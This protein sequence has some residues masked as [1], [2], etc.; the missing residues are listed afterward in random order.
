MMGM[1]QHDDG[2]NWKSSARGDQAWKEVTD[3]VAS[4]NADAR[5][6]G[7]SRRETYERNRAD[8][9]RAGTARQNSQLRD[10]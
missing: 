7:K 3:R 9:R 1:Q 6:A 2:S 5:K 10:R 8:V 4:R